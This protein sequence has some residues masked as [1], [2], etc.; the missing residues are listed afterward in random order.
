MVRMTC[1]PTSTAAANQRLAKRD[2]HL[3]SVTFWVPPDHLA[4]SRFGFKADCLAAQGH[5][6]IS[7]TDP[8]RAEAVFKDPR[9]IERI[10]PCWTHG[11]EPVQ[12][13]G[14]SKGRVL[15]VVYTRHG[16]SSGRT[17]RL[18][19]PMPSCC[20]SQRSYEATDA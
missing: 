15:F 18:P 7:L 1:A 8:A 14:T 16:P 3:L 20:S 5:C 10:D 11:K 9:R 12:V 13:I 6:E 17:Q 4:A 2:D 19:A